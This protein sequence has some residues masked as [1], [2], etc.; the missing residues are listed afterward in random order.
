MNAR[1]AKRQACTHAATLIIT[2]MAEG[3]PFNDQERP[4]ADE[5]RIS[6]ALVSLIH[7]LDNR[8]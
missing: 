6:R 8:G 1:E 2:A 5:D 7:E 3:W 4:P